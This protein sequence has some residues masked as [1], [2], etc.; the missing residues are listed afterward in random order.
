MLRKVDA[1]IHYAAALEP[2][3]IRECLSKSDR[4]AHLRSCVYAFFAAPRVYIL[5]GFRDFSLLWKEVCL[6]GSYCSA[7]GGSSALRGRSSPRNWNNFRF[8]WSTTELIHSISSVFCVSYSSSRR[9]AMQNAADRTL[10]CVYTAE[11]TARLISA[12]HYLLIIVLFTTAGQLEGIPCGSPP[13]G[14]FVLLY[15]C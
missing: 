1:V 8:L 2:M 14:F 9:C 3:C 7:D 15:C 12:F 13:T 5:C 4:M 10:R 6:A 11:T